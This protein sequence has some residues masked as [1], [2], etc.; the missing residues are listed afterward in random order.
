MVR[1]ELV[2]DNKTESCYFSLSL[3]SF[4]FYLAM[5]YPPDPPPFLIAVCHTFLFDEV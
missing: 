4:L 3:A 2:I 1:D 5:F